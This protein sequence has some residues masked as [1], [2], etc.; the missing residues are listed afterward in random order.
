MFYSKFIELCK[1]KGVSPTT[2]VEAIGLNRSNATYW[3]RGSVPR[4]ETIHKLAN[5]F[6]VPVFYFFGGLDPSNP[7]SKEYI[8]KYISGKNPA[9][10]MPEESGIF[11]DDDYKLLAQINGL[12]DTASKHFRDLLSKMNGDE[13]EDLLEYMKFLAMKRQ[14]EEER[15]K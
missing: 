5:Y 4:M 12:P 11:T 7:D 15:K 1:Q 9:F 6:S 2:A 3:K 8:E 14:H 10:P 13:L